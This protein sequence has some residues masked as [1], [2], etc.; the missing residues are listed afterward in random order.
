MFFRLTTCFANFLLD[1][2][3]ISGNDK[4]G[5]PG[6]QIYSGQ[7]SVVMS[8]F[9]AT[10]EKDLFVKVINCHWFLWPP[11][12]S[13]PIH[14][15]FIR[16]PLSG[17]ESVCYENYCLYMIRTGEPDEKIPVCWRGISTF[18]IPKEKYASDTKK[19]SDIHIQNSLWIFCRY[20]W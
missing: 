16:Y 9:C 19:L 6:V 1:R 8:L 13:L 12:P 20:V 2:T 10:G 15:L 11:Y 14:D 17:A 5:Q 3:W 18:G 7:N 4:S